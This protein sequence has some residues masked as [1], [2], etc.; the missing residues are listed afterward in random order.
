M[1]SLENARA[2]YTFEEDPGNVIRNRDNLRTR[3]AHSADIQTFSSRMARLSP[4]SKAF[5]YQRCHSKYHWFHTLRLLLVF[6][7]ASEWRVFTNRPLWCAVLIGGL[8][9]LAIELSQ[10]FLPTRDS[11][12][13]D[14]INNIIAT[15]AGSMLGRVLTAH[16]SAVESAVAVH[17]HESFQES[18]RTL[19]EHRHSIASTIEMVPEYSKG[20]EKT[21][22]DGASAS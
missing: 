16:T 13:L 15:L 21:F 6:I 18:S 11:S 17:Q 5:G 14:L 19:I 10:V 7:F 4:S 9:S 1:D 8:T 12:A 20:T 3:L 2:L 22:I